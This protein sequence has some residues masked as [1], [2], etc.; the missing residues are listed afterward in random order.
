MGSW[1]VQAILR[2]DANA[3]IGTTVFIAIVYVLVNLLT[4]ILYTVVDP[5]ISID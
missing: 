1:A 3:I 5:R 2:V 4:D